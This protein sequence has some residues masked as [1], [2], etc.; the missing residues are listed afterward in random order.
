MF[1][2]KILQETLNYGIENKTTIY[3]SLKF[4]SLGI[5]ITS[6]LTNKN[7][8]TFFTIPNIILLLISGYFSTIFAVYCH[9]IFLEKETPKDIVDILK[10]DKRKTNFLIT[11]IVLALGT[12]ICIV[13]VPF[14]LIYLGKFVPELNDFIL[15]FILTLP[16]GYVFSRLFLILPA[17]AID[18]D[19]SWSMAWHIS[20]GNGWNLCLLIFI[21]P[22]LPSF[23][24]DFISSTSLITKIFTSI[25]GLI[26]LFYGVSVLSNTYKVLIA[27]H[28]KPNQSLHQTP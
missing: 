4:P 24:P 16:I 11:L 12:C 18:K 5:L 19:N 23:V 14:I 15:W 8:E 21:L 10:W 28:E 26:I 1:I 17:T 13:P 22:M 2:K 3:N 7:A 20:K 6:L 9:R 25:M 27:E